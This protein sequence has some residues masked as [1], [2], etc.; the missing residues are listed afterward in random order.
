MVPLQNQE[1]G[2]FASSKDILVGT[3]NQPSDWEYFTL[4]TINDKDF[5]LKANR[6]QKFL[7]VVGGAIYANATVVG[8][9]ET[10]TMVENNGGYVDSKDDGFNTLVEEKTALEG[11]SSSASILAIGLGL[12]ALALF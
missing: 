7:S 6:N 12:I 11:G 5:A 2:Y 1:N 9:A 8:P 3:G 10:F 4:V